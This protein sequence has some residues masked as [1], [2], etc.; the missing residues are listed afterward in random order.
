MAVFVENFARFAGIAASFRKV[1][2]ITAIPDLLDI[3]PQTGAIITIDPSV[4]N[5]ISLPKIPPPFSGHD[6]AQNR[7]IVLALRPWLAG[8]QIVN[9][10]KCDCIG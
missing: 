10:G 1:K 7:P 6:P 5:A 8:R 9:H 2:E 4:A 3:L